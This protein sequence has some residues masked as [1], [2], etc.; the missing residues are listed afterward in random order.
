VEW[1]TGAHHARL[2]DREADLLELGAR[3]PVYIVLMETGR[4]R[5]TSVIWKMETTKVLVSFEG[6]RETPPKKWNTCRKKL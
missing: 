6:W 1:A 2:R 5:K 3:Q 4:L